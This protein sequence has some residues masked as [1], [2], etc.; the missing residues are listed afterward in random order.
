MKLQNIKITKPLLKPFFIEV[1]GSKHSDPNKLSCEKFEIINNFYVDNYLL[2]IIIK[3]TNKDLHIDNT[4]IF[5]FVNRYLFYYVKI[6]W[7]VNNSSFT[8]YI[9]EIRSMEEINR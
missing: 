7:K 8:K 2:K 6:N 4:I 9:I 1:A 3:Y 5:K